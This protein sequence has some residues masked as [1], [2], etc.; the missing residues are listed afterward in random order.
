[1]EPSPKF[2]FEAELRKWRRMMADT[3]L[4]PEVL[5]E[6][7]EHLREDFERQVR[8][9]AG[10]AE[11]WRVGRERIGSA[12]ALREEFAIAGG[13][14]IVATLR[15]HKWKLVLCSVAGLVA[16]VALQVVRPGNYQS[17]AKMFFRFVVAEATPGREEI[18]PPFSQAQ[19]EAMTI[20]MNDQIE[21]FMSRDL[22][23]E[24][25]EKIGPGKILRKAGG[26]ED[27]ERAADAIRAGL[28]VWKLPRSAVINLSFHHPDSAVVQPVLREVI[29]RFLRAYMAR[30]RPA[31]PAGSDHAITVGSITNISLIQAPAPPFFDFTA[32]L[33]M[34]ALAIA[35]GVMGGLGWVWAMARAGRG[36][37]RY[38]R[39]RAA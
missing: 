2:D 24:V 19:S 23:R 39:N 15:R 16:A 29:E 34:Q 28:R 13:E 4:A 32:L 20:A 22:V 9:G 17:E 27:L 36:D 18:A 10:E 25:A 33:R 6:L 35:A 3:G 12:G 21:I 7:E 30:H 38:S 26:G 11:A 37:G 14:G 1:M 31:R 5:A 8:G